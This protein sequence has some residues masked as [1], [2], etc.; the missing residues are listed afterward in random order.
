MKKVFVKIAVF[1]FAAVLA[2][3][4]CLSFAGCTPGT[5][6][7]GGNGGQGG[8][9]EHVH[10]YT[11]QSVPATCQKKAHTLYVCSCGDSYED[12]FTGELAAHTG[13]VKCSVCGINYYETL[14]GYIQKKGELDEAQY[15]VDLS[16]SDGVLLALYNPSTGKATVGTGVA[17]DGMSAVMTVTIGDAK[18]SYSWIMSIESSSASWTMIGTVTASSFTPETSSLTETLGTV[19]TALK[20][21]ARKLAASQM[22][23]CVIGLKTVLLLE[24]SG[25]TAANFGFTSFVD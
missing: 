21:T 20:A 5:D 22:K 15:V 13:S 2:L 3:G 11:E 8:T 19:P 4:A 16:T 1:C 18:G 24:G 10:S 9:G 14:A 6:N 25:V 12:D 7:S 17:S 23:S